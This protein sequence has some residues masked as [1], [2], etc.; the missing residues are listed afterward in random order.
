[1]ITL[2]QILILI[3]GI[4]GLLMSGIAF[5]GYGMDPEGRGS[6]QMG[7]CL[8]GGLVSLTAIGYPLV[9]WIWR[10]AH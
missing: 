8:L 2:V 10:I 3:L 9:T 1:M 6:A 5:M 4:A 7:W